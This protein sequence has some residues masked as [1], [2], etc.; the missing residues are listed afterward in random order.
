M[1][2]FQIINMKILACNLLNI[3]KYFFN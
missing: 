3:K 1:I 2:T